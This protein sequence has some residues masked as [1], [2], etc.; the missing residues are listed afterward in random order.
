MNRLLSNHVTA[1][2]FVMPMVAPRMTWWQHVQAVSVA[3]VH[4]AALCQAG[5]RMLL[6]GVKQKEAFSCV[7]WR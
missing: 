7:A 2:G 4:A 1:G 5:R 6:G 3:R